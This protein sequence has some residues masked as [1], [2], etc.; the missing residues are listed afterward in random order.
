MRN[1]NCFHLRS[2]KYF[3]KAVISFYFLNKILNLEWSQ[4]YRIV[5]KIVWILLIYVKLSF[6]YYS[7]SVSPSYLSIVPISQLMNQ[8]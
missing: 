7:N 4:L 1:P 3:K 5:V 2:L 6:L 8:Y